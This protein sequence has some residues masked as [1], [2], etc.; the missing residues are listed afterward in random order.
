MFTS[1]KKKYFLLSFG[2]KPAST[3]VCNLSRKTATIWSNHAYENLANTAGGGGG[4][5][6]DSVKYVSIYVT[7]SKMKLLVDVVIE[8]QI[9]KNS[10]VESVY[11]QFDEKF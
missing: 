8:G 7:H 10:C 9:K 3:A 4:G 1:P 6:Q 2:D 5:R 11:G